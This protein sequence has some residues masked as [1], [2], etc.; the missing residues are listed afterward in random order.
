MARSIKASDLGIVCLRN[1]DNLEDV[2]NVVGKEHVSRT[3]LQ[4]FNSE[5]A[6]FSLNIP[7]QAQTT[8]DDQQLITELIQNVMDWYRLRLYAL[9]PSEGGA[10]AYQTEGVFGQRCVIEYKDQLW[11]IGYKKD[12]TTP[13]VPSLC[14]YVEAG[15]LTL[16]QFEQDMIDILA[17]LSTHHGQPVFT[18]ELFGGVAGEFGVGLKRSILYMLQKDIAFQMR[19]TVPSQYGA[20]L[21]AGF[22]AVQARVVSG[23]AMA[24]VLG[25][26]QRP[27]CFPKNIPL[28]KL[29]AQWQPIDLAHPWLMQRLKWPAATSPTEEAFCT[30]ITQAHLVLYQGGP[31]SAWLSPL[32]TPQREDLSQDKAY[33]FR[34]AEPLL[35]V[36]GILSG[37]LPG[38]SWP[39]A[40]PQKKHIAVLCCVRATSDYFCYQRATATARLTV[41][42]AAPWSAICEQPLSLHMHQLMHMLFFN[43][44]TSLGQLVLT[45]TD[46]HVKR[47][48]ARALQGWFFVYRAQEVLRV[49]QCSQWKTLQLALPVNAH[50]LDDAEG[51]LLFWLDQ[52]HVEAPIALARTAL[53]QACAPFMQPLALTAL[54]TLQAGAQYIIDSTLYVHH[55]L[56]HTL[57]P[58]GLVLLKA[59]AEPW[60]NEVYNTAANDYIIQ[61]SANTVILLVPNISQATLYDMDAYL[62][63]M[64]GLFFT[65][66][67][68]EDTVLL[69]R[70][71]LHC[72][73]TRTTPMQD[74][75]DALKGGH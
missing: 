11:W 43:T 54:P 14:I 12:A 46:V 40:P 9:F 2:F 22:S 69:Q 72:L 38:T 53:Q 57:Y 62:Q 32:T 63:H 58:N 13:I 16:V 20:A 41:L 31:V 55:F 59:Y 67:A 47:Q 25:Q 10:F 51:S 26:Y 27:P 4:S 23:Q 60:I 35:Y 6:P 68:A 17:L 28:D 64:V 52:S 30:F 36:N 21:M 75:I 15:V 71:L 44:D 65:L 34:A 74:M 1:R 24:A 73:K 70:Y 48:V 49:R 45:S 61:E 5:S 8:L 29:P 7:F 37:R 39:G 33:L 3:P 42:M 19:G 66:W 50:L 56:S 18:P